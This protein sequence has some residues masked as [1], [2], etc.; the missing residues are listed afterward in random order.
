MIEVAREPGD[1]TA[2]ACLERCCF[3][4]TPTPYWD[5]INDV[6]CCEACA[7]THTFTDLP[8]KEAWCA[9]EREIMREDHR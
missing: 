4:R 8:T 9:R 2:I 7:T 6:A 3:C 5:L 1:L